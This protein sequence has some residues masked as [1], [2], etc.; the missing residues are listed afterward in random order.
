MNLKQLGYLTAIMAM[1]GIIALF[2]RLTEGDRGEREI[3]TVISIDE[4]DV[5]RIELTE[6]GETITLEPN[7]E[8]WQLTT[9]VTYPADQTYVTALLSNLEALEVDGTA[10]RN[11]ER[12][13]EFQVT[14][15]LGLQVR[16]SENDGDQTVFYLGKSPTGRSSSNYLRL[17]GENEVYTTRSNI[18]INFDREVNVWRDRQIASVDLAGITDVERFV[19]QES[20]WNIQRQADGNW[21]LGEQATDRAAVDALLSTLANLRAV[22]FIDDDSVLLNEETANFRIRFMANGEEQELLFLQR[23]T[24]AETE[25][26]FD[27]NEYFVRLGNQT[28][29]I[30]EVIYQDL[31]LTAEQLIFTIEEPAVEGIP[32]ETVTEE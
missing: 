3:K 13:S 26:G 15:E 23:T 31:A 8:S 2:A 9:P 7:G 12:Q 20:A 27:T 11:Q 24:P 14:P 6:A 18:R 32:T 19:S 29:V 25:E 10:S 22:D 28:F 21:L 17:E 30:S 16:I 4:Q 1:L 5:T